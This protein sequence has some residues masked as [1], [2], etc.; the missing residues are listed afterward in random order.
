MRLNSFSSEAD[1]M[2]IPLSLVAEP[3]NAKIADA[4]KIHLQDDQLVYTI[5]EVMRM[6]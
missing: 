6:V 5:W 3:Y 4:L 1:L 2:T